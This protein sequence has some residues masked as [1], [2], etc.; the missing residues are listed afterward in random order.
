MLV[1]PGPHLGD[2]HVQE[3]KRATLA[4]IQRD[5]GGRVAEGQRISARLH[6]LEVAHR[7]RVVEVRDRTSERELRTTLGLDRDASVVGDAQVVTPGG[8][9]AGFQMD[10][11]GGEAELGVGGHDPARQARDQLA[12]DRGVPVDEQR[13]PAGRQQVARER[14]IAGGER[15]ASGDG[16]RAAPGVPPSGRPMLQLEQIGH[17]VTEL[18]AQQLPEHP[19][20]AIEADGV[21]NP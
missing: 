14:T 18:A 11:R 2:P 19:V 3:G 20:V 15:M 17:P 12:G 21:A 5:D 1:A 16:Q 8:E 13:G 6:A 7:A 4:P 10:A 9:L